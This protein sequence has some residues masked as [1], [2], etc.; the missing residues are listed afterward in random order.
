AGRLPCAG[1][2]PLFA[3]KQGRNRRAAALAQASKR[4]AA[5]Q[6]RL[7]FSRESQSGAESCCIGA[8]KCYA[9]YLFGAKTEPE[10]CKKH[11][12]L[13]RRWSTDGTAGSLRP[14]PARQRRAGAGDVEIFF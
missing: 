10:E 13:G 11:D 5:S 12:K 14:T 4:H 3:P 6:I 9:S 2:V 7:W 1:F 8:K